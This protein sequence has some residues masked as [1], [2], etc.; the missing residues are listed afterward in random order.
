MTIRIGFASVDLEEALQ[1]HLPIRERVQTN[2]FFAQ[3]GADAAVW[4]VLDFMDFDLS[5]VRELQCAVTAVVPAAANHVH[6]LTTHNHGAGTCDTLHRPELAELT[7]R[8]AL[9]A[10]RSAREACFRYATVRV[11]RPVSYLRRIFVPEVDGVLTVFYGPTMDDNLDAAPFIQHYLDALRVGTLSFTGSTPTGRTFTPFAPADDRLDI[12]QFAGLD[13]APLGSFIR[14]AA[15]AVCCNNPTFHTSDYPWH[16]RTALLRTLGGQ[17]SVFFNGPC[18]DIAPTLHTKNDGTERTLGEYLAMLALN[19]IRS[20]PYVPL[21]EFA[22]FSHD[23]QLPVRRELLTGTLSVPA[24]SNGLP[25]IR[26]RLESLHLRD[27]LPFLR[28][29]YLNG[30]PASGAGGTGTI[31]VTLGAMR[32]NS[33]LILAFPGETFS[34]TAAAV[35]RQFP[36]ITTVTE[37][38][39]TAMYMPPP[40]QYSLGGYEPQGAVTS[41]DAEPIL[42][43]HA[44]EFLL[45]LRSYAG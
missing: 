24:Q 34:T 18:A 7:A 20:C 1:P 40:E 8:A 10:A 31:R 5:I 37:H 17:A 29:K 38:G 30:V 35:V 2:V 26:R 16:I 32:L 3:N 27:T 19:A 22:D 25:E 14:F 45:T 6:I 21:T 11:P 39:R 42:R 4:C 12:F 15:H 9:A 43:Q 13:G 44:A 33:R 41:P 23:V 36:D 28:A